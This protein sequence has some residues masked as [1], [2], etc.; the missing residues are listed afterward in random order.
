MKTSGPLKLAVG[1]KVSR[2]SAPSVT[3]PPVTASGTPTVIA[4]P[5][6]AVT[7]SALPSRS[8]SLT[9]TSKVTDVSSAV[10]KLSSTATG[11]SF[12]PVT[13]T[14]TVAVEKPPAPSEIV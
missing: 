13:V 14:V 6:M 11:A 1:A 12:S 3:V 7:V 5:L 9:R 10:V 4:V 2:P 8:R